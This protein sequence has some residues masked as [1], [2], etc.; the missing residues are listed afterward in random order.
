MWSND[1][2]RILAGAFFALLAAAQ[3][4]QFEVAS[5]KV[6]QPPA[7]GGMRA[8]SQGGPG[9]DDAGLFTCENLPVS[10][11][12]IRAFNIK[13]YQ[14][15]GRT[16]MR[17]MRFTVSAKIPAGVT[18]K[19]F[20]QMMQNLL[21]ERLKLKVHYEKK[22]MPGY[23]L[24]IA[25]NG[26]KLKNSSGPLNP[27]EKRPPESEAKPDA[28]GF[29]ILPPGRGPMEMAIGW[30]MTARYAEE[31]M[32]DLA[33][34]VAQDLSSPVKDATGLKGKYDFT[35]R[36]VD[37]P[38]GINTDEGGPNMIR[39]LQEQLGLKLES[40]KAMVDILIV[41]HIEKTPTAN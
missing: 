41:D 24:V 14:F 36:W 17:S 34:S 9:T 33:A 15:P 13:D 20:N 31:T 35:L 21:V 11:L 19:Q 29:P 3:S 16:G 12:I 22:E 30:H 5:I 18:E 39:A 38:P 23:D 32:A 27:A 7:D 28:Q 8:W 4:P 1:I 6:S 10:R 26:P 25:K 37:Q 40:K 2:M